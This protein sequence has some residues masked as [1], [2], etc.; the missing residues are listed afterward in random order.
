MSRMF[1]GT[2]HL[3]LTDVTMPRMKGPELASR[4]V[5]DRPGTRVLYMSGYN[6]ESMPEEET[7]LQKPFS[8]QTLT[9]TL[10][11]I[12]DAEDSLPRTATA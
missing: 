6:D 9:Q 5:H 4:L 3:L 7:I 2:I 1:R 10:R 8:A 12:L 11:A